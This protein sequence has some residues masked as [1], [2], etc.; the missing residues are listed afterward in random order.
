MTQSPCNNKIVVAKLSEFNPGQS[1][2]KFMLKPVTLSRSSKTSK[3]SE[4]K[5]DSDPIFSLRSLICNEYYKVWKYF[6]IN[7]LS[8]VPNRKNNQLSEDEISIT[9]LEIPIGN[10]HLVLYSNN[11]KFSKV[12]RKMEIQTPMY[13]PIFN[14]FW[15]RSKTLFSLL[16]R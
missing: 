1:I 3:Q 14:Q 4:I 10:H 9:L 12:Q 16:M 5:R 7:F 8:P 6:F 2:D 11:S 15:L 13:I